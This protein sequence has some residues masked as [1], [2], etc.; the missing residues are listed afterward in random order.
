MRRLPEA[1]TIDKCWS[2]SV[3][4]AAR[5]RAVSTQDDTTVAITE[6]NPSRINRARVE[7]GLYVAPV[8]SLV[9]CGSVHVAVVMAAKQ[10]KQAKLGAEMSDARRVTDNLLQQANQILEAMDVAFVD[11]AEEGRVGRV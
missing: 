8:S 6:I 7:Q 9:W 4:A 5:W 3:C 11:A 10:T 1:R 2:I